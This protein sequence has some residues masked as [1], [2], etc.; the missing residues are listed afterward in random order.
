MTAADW[1]FQGNSLDN[2]TVTFKYGI[3]TK[4]V[5]ANQAFK[6]A[7]V[8][9]KNYFEINKFDLYELRDN[10]DRVEVTPENAPL[11]GQYAG[12]TYIIKPSTTVASW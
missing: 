11:S 12:K 7:V 2:P 8:V 3:K 4:V 10:G 5:D 1:R 9:A 6:D